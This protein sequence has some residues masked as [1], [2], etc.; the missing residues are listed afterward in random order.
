MKKIIG[1]LKPYVPE[2]PAESVKARLGVERLVRLSAN[3]NPYGTSP[4][5]REA[6]LDYVTNNDAN[7]YPDGNASSLRSVLADYWKVA[8]SQL[9][10]VGLDE[11]ISMVN[12][13]FG[14]ASDSTSSAFLLFR[15]R[16]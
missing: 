11:V 16:P 7:L 15:I 4:K 6:V 3:E 12:K 14:N 8:E 2:E 10:G 5:V 13:T 1:Q 9:I